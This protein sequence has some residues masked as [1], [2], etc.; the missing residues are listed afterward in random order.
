MVQGRVV[1]YQR[2]E[3]SHCGCA[4]PMQLYVYARFMVAGDVLI[5]GEVPDLWSRGGEGEIVGGS[6][7][8][9][10]VLIRTRELSDVVACEM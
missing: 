1:D 7:M 9:L 4:P 10:N 5:F 2:S 6:F 8:T 3:M